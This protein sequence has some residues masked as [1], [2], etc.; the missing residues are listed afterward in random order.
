M[1]KNKSFYANLVFYLGIAVF[2]LVF[3][4][5]IGMRSKV[6]HLFFDFLPLIVSLCG[7]VVVI[8]SIK[9]TRRMH[10]IF[11]GFQMIFWG[12]LFFLK[13]ID[14]F[15]FSLYEYWPVVGIA[16]GLFLG[17]SGLVKYK[18][19]LFG[20]FIPSIALFL[21]GIWF[22][23]FSF[24]I[25]KIPFKIVALVGAPLF[26]IMSGIFIIGLFLFQQKNANLMPKEDDNNGIETDEDFT[27]SDA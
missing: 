9:T 2:V 26:L 6:D 23:L 14:I 22:S 1:K 12:L 15:Y 24:S 11:I 5:Y 25:I 3:C 27:D 18:K 10:Q 16:S 13:S 7:L 8:F 20:Y 17:I 19:P 4:I 21:L